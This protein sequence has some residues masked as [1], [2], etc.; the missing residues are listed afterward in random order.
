MK[1][2]KL[3]TPLVILAIVAITHSLRRHNP[4]LLQQG[5]ADP[6]P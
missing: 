5:D 6:P 2:W 3:F 4:P 1:G